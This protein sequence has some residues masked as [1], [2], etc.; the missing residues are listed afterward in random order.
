MERCHGPAPKRADC[1][2]S[3]CARATVA[4]ASRQA[5]KP[6]NKHLAPVVQGICWWPF[7]KCAAT[8]SAMGPN[9]SPSGIGVP[10]FATRNSGTRP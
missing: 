10:R 6:L 3:F 9:S 4:L 8:R 5:Q 1:M 2:T 7:S